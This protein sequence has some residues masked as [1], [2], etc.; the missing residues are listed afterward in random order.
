MPI[1]ELSNGVR[2]NSDHY[3]KVYQEREKRGM[4]THSSV[5]GEEGNRW[6][7]HP[8][9]GK[10]VT[11]VNDPNVAYIIETIHLHWYYGGWY[12]HA[13]ARA[14]GTKSHTTFFIA[15]VNSKL[16]F[17]IECIEKFNKEFQF[18]KSLTSTPLSVE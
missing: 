1:H 10:R 9:E 13:V 14:E 6:F 7:G 17:I 18:E 15:N 16:P 8:L 12:L 5:M 11:K 2:F 4:T 3:S